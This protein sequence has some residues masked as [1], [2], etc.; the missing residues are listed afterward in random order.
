LKQARKEQELLLLMLQDVSVIETDYQDKTK[1]YL[2]EQSQFIIANAKENAERATQGQ[3]INQILSGFTVLLG[4]IIAVY[5]TRSVVKP[6]RMVTLDLNRIAQGDYSFNASESAVGRKDEIGQMANA[7]QGVLTTM[8]G[9]L[10]QIA[11]SSKQLADSSEGL[12]VG[13]EQAAQAANQVAGS[14][15]EIASGAANQL[16]TMDEATK[17]VERMSSGIKQ[18][19]DHAAVVD[20]TTQKTLQVAQTGEDKVKSAINQIENIS[21]VV[22]SANEIVATLGIRSKEIGQIVDTISGIAGQTN[23]LA[24]NAAI[25]AARAGEQG[26][27]FAVVAEEVRKLA[28]QSEQAAKQITVLIGEIQGDTDKAVVAMSAGTNEVSMGIDVVNTA[29]RS[30]IDIA[31]LV[32]N[33]SE[34]TR[35]ISDAIQDMANS[36]QQIVAAVKKVSH[37]GKSAA[38][39]T[40]TVSA[41][42][43]EQSALV[44]EIAASSKTLGRMAEE[45]NNITRSFKV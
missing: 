9:I 4:L 33:L 41:S 14:V 20:V 27:G 40:E 8:R 7:M 42:T 15:T 17:S 11:A 24:L 18:V 43:Q 29:G 25:E 6:I 45:L 31:E 44:E 32:A 13:A 38:I 5:I 36:S 30:F 37:I 1:E 28:E 26:R 3:M 19:A 16:A 2:E 23:L 22:A 21:N 10:S 34:Q 39:E 35:N 12:I